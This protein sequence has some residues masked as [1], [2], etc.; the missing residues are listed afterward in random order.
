MRYRR[1][2]VRLVASYGTAGRQSAA[3]IIG[4]RE[5]LTIGLDIASTDTLRA[6]HDR[7]DIRPSYELASLAACYLRCPSIVL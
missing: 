1:T 4:R 3:L 5:E 7:L 2:F 6:H